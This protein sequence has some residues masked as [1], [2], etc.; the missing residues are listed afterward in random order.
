MSTVIISTLDIILLAIMHCKR[1][2][3]RPKDGAIFVV[4]PA[5]A[6]LLMTLVGFVWNDIHSD[7]DLEIL[8]YNERVV[9]E[10]RECAFAVSLFYSIIYYFSSHD[11]HWLV[12]IHNPQFMLLALLDAMFFGGTTD[13][14]NW[15]NARHTKVP[16]V[17]FPH[18]LFF[19]V[20]IYEF[21]RECINERQHPVVAVPNIRLLKDHLLHTF[22]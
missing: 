15:V 1:S 2:R 19:M 22:T 7:I 9:I 10:L 14:A 18:L 8:M 12:A 17:P 5:V 16:F 13:I 4:V 6:S 11:H 20:V 21:I 3:E